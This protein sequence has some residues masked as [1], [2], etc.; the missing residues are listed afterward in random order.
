MN[1]DF[2][3]LDALRLFVVQQQSNKPTLKVFASAKTADVRSCALCLWCA[4]VALWC[5]TLIGS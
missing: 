4:G 1:E 5:C 3:S 2:F